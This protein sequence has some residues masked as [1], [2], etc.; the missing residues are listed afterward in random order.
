MYLVTY[1]LPLSYIVH[2][3]LSLSGFHFIL[4]RRTLYLPLPFHL[5]KHPG[6]CNHLHRYFVDML[7]TPARGS[8]LHV[9]NMYIVLPLEC[10]RYE[11]TPSI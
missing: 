3:V 6:H 10:P 8:C 1:A 7:R 9:P 11:V 4:D 5:S 2:W